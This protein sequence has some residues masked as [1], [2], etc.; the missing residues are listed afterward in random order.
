MDMD[1]H[2]FGTIPLLVLFAAVSLLLFFVYSPFLSVLSLAGVSAVM[3]HGPHE[4]LTRILGGRSGISALIMVLLLCIFF[5]V[6][7]FFLGLQIFQE[8]QNLFVGIQG[9]G[10][11]YVEAVRNVIQVPLQRWVPGF[12]FDI[13]TAVENVILFISSN[14]GSL[15]YQT[16]SVFFGAFLMLLSLFFF[17]RDGRAL[18]A[19]FVDLSPFGKGVTDEILQ[20]MY[21][22]IR[23]VVRGTLFIVVIRAACMWVAFTLFGIPNA[24]FWGTLGGVAG[25]IPGLGT[26][27]AFLGAAVYFYLMGNMAGVIGSILSGGIA[28][29][30]VDNILTSY[31]FGKGLAVSPIF[32]LFAILGGLVYFGPLGFIL[33]PL[34]LSVFLSVVRISPMSGH[35]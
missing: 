7:L 21:L 18:L 17:L 15:V 2:R 32:V 35:A 16:L 24:L 11:S 19:S 34:V 31:F 12:V 22:T 26:A 23:S 28:V 20:N 9:N 1:T 5:V 27:F 29:I 10:A 14:L 25:A 3:L 33:G 6:P 8:A 30:L 4:K 13:H